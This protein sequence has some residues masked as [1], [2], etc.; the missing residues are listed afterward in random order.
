LSFLDPILTTPNAPWILRNA[1]H[2]H[3]VARMVEPAFDRRA[4]NRGLLGR[5]GIPED[6]ALILAPCNSIHTFFMRFAIDVAFV[7]RD[8]HIR[9]ARQALQPWRIQVVPRAFAVVELASGALERSD[10]RV[11]DRL[12]VAAE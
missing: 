7:D 9:H 2:E 10:T 11:G 3:V 5:A 4:R 12:Y 1:R 8:G 6:T